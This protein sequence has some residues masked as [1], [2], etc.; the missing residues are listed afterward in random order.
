MSEA[1]WIKSYPRGV[2]LDAELMT[3][4]VQQILERSAAK[5]QYHPALDFM[6]KKIRYR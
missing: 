1:P 6:N 4:P 2:R 5:W 3:M